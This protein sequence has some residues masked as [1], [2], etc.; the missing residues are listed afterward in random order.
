MSGRVLVRFLAASL[1]ANAEDQIL[2]LRAEIEF[3]AY[4]RLSE[5]IL[6]LRCAYRAASRSALAQFGERIPLARKSSFS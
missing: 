3:I 2:T 4:V 6:L 1:Q 5:T